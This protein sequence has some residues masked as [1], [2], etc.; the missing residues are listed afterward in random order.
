MEGDTDIIRVAG[1]A[2]NLANPTVSAHREFLLDQLRISV[3]L[4]RVREI[5]LVNHEDCGAYGLDDAVD[6]DQE[7]HVHIADLE[8]ADQIIKDAIPD[9]KV[10][11]YFLRLNGR[12]DTVL[13][14]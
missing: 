9:V 3:D 11:A 6:S 7:L 8:K 1:V 4:H 10:K 5:Y 14:R 2:K 13:K 12:V